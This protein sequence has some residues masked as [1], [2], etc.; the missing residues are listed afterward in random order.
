MN[1]R[2]IERE[3]CRIIIR[4]NT[5]FVSS[6]LQL[7]IFEVLK[8]LSRVE[9][10]LI[11]MLKFKTDL[12]SLGAFLRPSLGPS[13]VHYKWPVIPGFDSGYGCTKFHPRK[14]L[15]ETNEHVDGKVML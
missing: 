13:T 7:R 2:L 10:V 15:A 1:A 11:I 3:N 8:T 12:R 14:F 5:R 9:T 6:L 4:D